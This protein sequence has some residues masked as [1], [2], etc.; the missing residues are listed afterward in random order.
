MSPMVLG[1]RPLAIGTLVAAL[2]GAAWAQ[3][4]AATPSPGS[5]GGD[6]PRPAGEVVSGEQL[7]ATLCGWCHEGGGRRAGK[8]PKLAGITQTDTY[9]INRIKSGR[10]QSGMPAFGRA[11]SEEQIRAIVAYIRALP[12][13]GSR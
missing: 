4:Q 10:P 3:E 12:D 11:F 7:F 2:A 6:A 8:G 5:A 9:I 13:D 1:A